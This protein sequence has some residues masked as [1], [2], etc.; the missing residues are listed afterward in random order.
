M[1]LD[2]HHRVSRDT[3]VHTATHPVLNSVYS[4]PLVRKLAQIESY[5]IYFIT[6][7]SKTP[8]ASTTTD[9]R[10]RGEGNANT[11]SR[12]GRG[13]VEAVET[14]PSPDWDA[15]S[16]SWSSW[17]RGS[18]PLKDW[19]VPLTCKPP[20]CREGR[21]RGCLRNITIPMRSTEVQK[22]QGLTACRRDFAVPL[23]FSV[24][25][26]VKRLESYISWVY[27]GTPCTIGA[28]H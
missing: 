27:F 9:G 8:Q 21:R 10:R 1:P 6:P 17:N 28:V 2:L 3:A 20:N 19:S 11:L 13:T 26:C 18:L 15:S 5:P 7:W 12:Q 4:S 24:I 22:G 23:Y 14:L 25:V 16:T